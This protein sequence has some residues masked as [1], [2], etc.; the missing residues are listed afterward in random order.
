MTHNFVRLADMRIRPV[1]DPQPGDVS[2]LD[3]VVL[4]SA[5]LRWAEETR[6]E[7]PVQLRMNTTALLAAIVGA[8]HVPLHGPQDL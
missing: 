5:W 8:R 1:K 3:P 4:L 2:D 6:A 7:A